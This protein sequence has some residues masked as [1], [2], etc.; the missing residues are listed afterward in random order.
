MPAVVPMVAFSVGLIYY[1]WRDVYLVHLRQQRARARRVNERI[2]Y[3]L[4]T[5]AQL[6]S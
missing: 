5:A 4:W 1:H 3:M 2:A 6:V